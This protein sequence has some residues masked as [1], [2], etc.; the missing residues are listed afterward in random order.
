MPLSDTHAKRSGVRI[1][2]GFYSGSRRW[3]NRLSGVQIPAHRKLRGRRCQFDP[4]VECQLIGFEYPDI[5]HVITIRVKR[6][7]VVDPHISEDFS[8]LVHRYLYVFAGVVAV[9]SPLT[10]AVH[11]QVSAEYDRGIAA[12]VQ[13]AQGDRSSDLRVLRHVVTW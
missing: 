9:A 4:A 3:E 11:R 6:T 7:G 5:Q 8:A 12:N 2:P 1:Q 13:V 10:V